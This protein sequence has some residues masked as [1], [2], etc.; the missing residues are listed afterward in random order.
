ME[1]AG[2]HVVDAVREGGLQEEGQREGEETWRHE[3][4]EGRRVGGWRSVEGPRNMSR[5]GVTWRPEE[6]GR[7]YQRRDAEQDRKEKAKTR[8]FK[9][10]S[11]DISRLQ[12][13]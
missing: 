8:Q 1:R 7:G 2:E 9:D 5:E 11:V 13:E 12:E 4:M 6:E 3:A 10:G